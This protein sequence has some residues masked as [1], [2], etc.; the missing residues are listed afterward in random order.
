MEQENPQGSREKQ[1]AKHIISHGGKDKTVDMGLNPD[2]VTDPVN[3]FQTLK[4]IKSLRRLGKL[5]KKAKNK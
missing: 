3:P 1:N 4:D 5:P 2:T